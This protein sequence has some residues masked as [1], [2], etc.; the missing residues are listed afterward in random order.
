M[1]RLTGLIVILMLITL[2]VDVSAFEVPYESWMG[3]YVGVLS[4]PFYAVT[5]DDGT[6]ELKNVPPGKFLLEAWS[7]AFADTP[8]QQTVELKP[9]QVLE[10]NLEFKN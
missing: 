3:A 5:G 8:V 6:F 9:G 1:R 7:E 4:H 2:A 10:V